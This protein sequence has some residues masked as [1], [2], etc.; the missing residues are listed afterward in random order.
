MSTGMHCR[1]SGG[2]VG[3]DLGGST[4]YRARLVARLPLDGERHGSRRAEIVRRAWT[5]S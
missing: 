1:A 3:V 4:G 2:F 5:R